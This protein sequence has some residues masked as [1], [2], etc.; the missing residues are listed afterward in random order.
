MPAAFFSRTHAML[1]AALQLAG[2]GLHVFP[3]KPR[4]KTPVTAN[5][6]KDATTSSEKIRQWWQQ[7][8]DCNVA[9]RTGAISKIFVVDIDVDEDKYKYDGEDELRRLE[10]EHGELPATIESITGRGR[11]LFFRRPDVPVRS[12]VRKI[13]PGI[14]LRADD[15]YVISPPS[16]HATGRTYAWSVDCAPAVAHAP[17]WLLSKITDEPANSKLPAPPSEW[18][19]LVAEGVPEGRRDCTITKITGYLLR[20]YVD[21]IFVAELMQIFNAARCAPPLPAEDVER[22]VN[23]IAGKELRRRQGHG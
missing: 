15:A 8:P 17:D 13:A 3:C 11:H 16:V 14:D 20:R 18:R 22:I 9:I 12:S 7:S 19:A 23:S 21:P 6:F 10:A 2:R 5:G 4:G 1:R